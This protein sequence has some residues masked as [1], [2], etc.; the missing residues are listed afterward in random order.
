MVEGFAEATGL[1]LDPDDPDD[2][3]PQ[4]GSAARMIGAVIRNTSNPTMLDA[5]YKAN[6]IP[7]KA[8]ATIDARF[9]PG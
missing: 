1:D 4:L 8:E 3:L 6:V 2:W 5:G 9:L 7:S